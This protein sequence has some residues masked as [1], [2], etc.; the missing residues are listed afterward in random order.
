MAYDR[1]IAPVGW[2]DSFDWDSWDI[3]LDAAVLGE[4]TED[5]WGVRLPCERYACYRER[6]LEHQVRIRLDEDRYQKV[7]REAARRGVS[8]ADVIRDAIDQLPAHDE[9]RRKAI[10]AILAAAPM[11][12]PADPSTLRGELDVAHDRVVG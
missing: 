8:P 11:T 4:G 6:M 1:G 9:D 10:A 3:D 2:F 5:G 12:V 7:A